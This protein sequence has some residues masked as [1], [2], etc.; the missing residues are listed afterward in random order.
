MSYEVSLRGLLRTRLNSHNQNSLTPHPTDQPNQP[1]GFAGFARPQA[2]LLPARRH[3]QGVE[4]DDEG[5]ELDDG[6]AD[7]TLRVA[8]A[9]LSRLAGTLAALV[10]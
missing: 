3:R 10:K 4:L 8:L 5:V 7:P 2:F 1:R 9:G 6:R